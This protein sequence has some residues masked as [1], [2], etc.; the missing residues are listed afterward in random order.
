MPGEALAFDRS[1]G[2]CLTCHDIKGG[3]APGNVGPELSDMKSRYPDRKELARDHLR[4]DQAQSADRH[5]A[6]RRNLILTEQ[7]I[8][9]VID[10][11]YTRWSAAP[12]MERKNVMNTNESAARPDAA[13]DRQAALAGGLAGWALPDR[14]I[15]RAAAADA[16]IWPKDA[17]AQKTEADAIKALYG[18]D[19]EAS[20]KVNLDAPEIA[21]N[22]AV[23][24]ISVIDHASRRHLDRHPGLGK[25]VSA[26]ASYKIPPAL[27]RWSPIG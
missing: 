18:K 5:A 12:R 16:A 17:F 8:E 26:A 2:N 20:D 14:G 19:A 3:D 13:A 25:S 6:V 1:K 4:R 22:G 10:F 23:V 15:A 21:E 24:P 7:E 11:L 9:A 27:R